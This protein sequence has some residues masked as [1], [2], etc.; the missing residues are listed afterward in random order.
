MI[1][2]LI[3]FTFLLFILYNQTTKQFLK[4]YEEYVGVNPNFLT[5]SA[6]AP[7]AYDGVWTMAL[8]LQE[9]ERRLQNLGK[10]DVFLT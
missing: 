2:I 1:L 3:N 7:Y 4:E 10:E 9:A 8:L 5:G 6:D